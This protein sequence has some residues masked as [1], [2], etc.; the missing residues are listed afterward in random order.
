MKCK[1]FLLFSIVF[2]FFGWAQSITSE[3]VEYKLPIVSKFPIEPSNRTFKVKVTSPYTLKTDDI[4]AQS[5]LDYQAET[6]SFDKTVAASEVEFQKRLVAYD[7]DV[8]KAKEKYKLESEEYKKLSLLERLAMSDQGREPKLVL[9]TKPQYVK[10]TKAEYREPDLSNYIIVDNDVLASQISITGFSR[11]GNYIDV[12]VDIKR[13]NFQD[14]AGQTFANQP[15]KVIVKV[16]GVE[17]LNNSFFQ[18]FKLLSTSPSNN[19]NKPLE[20]KYYLNKVIAQINTFLDDNFGIRWINPSI[21]ISTV[22]N[23]G[24]YDDLEKATIYVTTNLRKL[25]P[26]NA[27]MNAAAMTGMQKGIDI[28]KATLTKIDYKDKKA[29]LNAKIA[30]YIYYNLIRLNIGL[31]NK[32]EAEKY[33]NELQENMIYLDL[34]SDEKTELKE[35]E[36]NIYKG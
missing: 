25:N 11:D 26:E 10:P 22:K 33:L 19:L 21:K 15:T 35:F 36:N 32:K 14:T 23:K 31:R 34:S 5:K 6:K 20:E 24:K 28:W 7:Q 8:V 17:K 4:I 2:S 9:P 13:M 30:T 29:D 27:E 1:A 18:E 3:K 12:A 16:N